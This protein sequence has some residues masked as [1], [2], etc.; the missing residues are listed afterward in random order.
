MPLKQWLTD[1]TGS[2]RLGRK[3][4]ISATQWAVSGTC[5]G[6]GTIASNLFTT[7]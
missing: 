3:D 6:S 5:L 1:L 4:M 7:V 2:V